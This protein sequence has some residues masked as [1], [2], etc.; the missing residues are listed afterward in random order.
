MNNSLKIL[1]ILTNKN[2]VDEFLRKEVLE[3]KIENPEVKLAVLFRRYYG[4]FTLID[5]ENLEPEQIIKKIIYF[6]RQKRF[7]EDKYWS[8]WRE[9]GF[10]FG[11]IEGFFHA[12]EGKNQLCKIKGKPIRDDFLIPNFRKT[13][14]MKKYKIENQIDYFKNPDVFVFRFETLEE[15]RVFLRVNKIER[16]VGKLANTKRGMH[17][18]I[19][20]S[21]NRVAKSEDLKQIFA[22]GVMN[23]A[24]EIDRYL[25]ESKTRITKNGIHAILGSF[26]GYGP[27]LVKMVMNLVFD[28]P[29]I[30]VDRRILRSAV[31]LSMVNLKEDYVARIKSKFEIEHSEMEKIAHKISSL[32]EKY[33]LGKAEDRLN[34]T[35]L[36]SPF[37]SEADYLLFMYNGGAGWNFHENMKKLDAK[38]EMCRLGKCCYDDTGV[39]R[40]R[41][42]V[43]YQEHSSSPSSVQILRSSAGPSLG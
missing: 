24:G 5:K 22:E 12:Q 31:M 10:F 41:R 25:F 43:E 27:K 9:D 28:I 11:F 14:I 39:C 21:V 40:L 8:I 38:G 17:F 29:I 26:M 30:A 18:N 23:E 34:Q 37:L 20:D 35:F 16:M 13:D 1:D 7:G 36:H 6:Q 32:S 15:F 19:Y 4:T 2:L 42:K 33:A 3:S